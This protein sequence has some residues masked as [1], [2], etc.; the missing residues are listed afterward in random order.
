MGYK[1]PIKVI[2]S[3]YFGVT[4]TSKSNGKVNCILFLRNLI[5]Q[6]FVLYFI[7]IFIMKVQSLD[8]N[9]HCCLQTLKM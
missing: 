6:L 1:L 3:T 8:D 9:K 2:K 7:I 4:K 5:L